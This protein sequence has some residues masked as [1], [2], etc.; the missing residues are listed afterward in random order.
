MGWMDYYR[1]YESYDGDLSKAS[2]DELRQAARNNPNDPSTAKR[3]A[4]E[5]WERE[6]QG[7]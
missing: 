1:L 6:K 4:K 3:I 2:K 5:T 7:R